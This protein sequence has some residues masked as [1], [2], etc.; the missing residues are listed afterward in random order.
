MW[1][2]AT[3]TGGVSGTANVDELGVDKMGVDEMG[4]NQIY[5]LYRKDNRQVIS[6]MIFLARWG[7]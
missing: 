5:I 2:G 1:G 6:N 7:W 4:V 3:R